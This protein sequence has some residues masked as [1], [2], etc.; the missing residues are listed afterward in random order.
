MPCKL[1]VIQ[2]LGNGYSVPS[3]QASFNHFSLLT[4]TSHFLCNYM[5]QNVHSTH[6]SRHFDVHLLPQMKHVSEAAF[7]VSLDVDAALVFWSWDLDVTRGGS[8]VLDPPWMSQCSHWEWKICY[9][10]FFQKAYVYCVLISSSY[11]ITVWSCIPFPSYTFPNG[12]QI[13]VAC[14]KHKSRRWYTG[15]WKFIFTLRVS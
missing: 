13:L 4:V 8:L 11:Y 12:S 3:W 7:G 1:Y 5:L 9:Y 10:T 2:Y 15:S 6:S 14:M